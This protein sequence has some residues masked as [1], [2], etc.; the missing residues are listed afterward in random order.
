VKKILVFL[1]AVI[2]L[3]AV[4]AFS[5]GTK[6]VPKALPKAAAAPAGVMATVNGE[7]I[8]KDDLAKTAFD[9]DGSMVLERMIM[10]KLMD[11]EAKKAGVVV[12]QKDVTAK[13]AELKKNMPP[14]QDFNDV[15]KRSGMT[16]NSAAAYMKMNLQVE[17]I[18]RKTIKVAPED[19][20]GYNKSEHILIRVPNATDP[21]E[22][23]KNEAD[24]KAKIEK[25]A[26]EIKGGLSFEEAAKKYSEDPMTKETGGDLDFRGPGELMPEFEN[27]AKALKPGEVSAPVKT[28]YGYHLI[29]LIANGKDA[30]G[31]DRKKLEDQMISKKM[32]EKWQEFMLTA[33]NKAKIVNYLDPEK[34]KP[35]APVAA[36]RPAGPRPAP[37]QAPEGGTP[38]PPPPAPAQP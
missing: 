15:L 37:A 1:S 20:A 25:I 13:F 3:S 24:A 30:K 21:K 23:D 33:R 14:G 17:S 9:W 28:S 31:A 11:Q 34:P 29:K 10:Y 32:G 6:V 18:I 26:A 4:P 5:A 35:A 22:K 36:P 12:T 27:A 8:T 19:L 16:P 7:K 38:P 2:I